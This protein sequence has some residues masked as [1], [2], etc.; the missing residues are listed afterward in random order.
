MNNQELKKAFPH[1]KFISE[2]PVKILI[3]AK[4]LIYVHIL[5]KTINSD[6]F[7]LTI[8]INADSEPAKI[9]NDSHSIYGF[10]WDNAEGKLNSQILHVIN[11]Y[12]SMCGLSDYDIDF[13]DVAEIAASNARFA[14]KRK[15]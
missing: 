5:D 10:G 12:C 11:N 13:N 4:K 14:E 3:N 15:K 2:D 1:C 8:K 9:L 7:N 6:G